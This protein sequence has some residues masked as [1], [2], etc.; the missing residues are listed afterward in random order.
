VDD[1]QE[2]RESDTPGYAD[3]RS[4]VDDVRKRTGKWAIHIKLDIISLGFS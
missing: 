3:H 2:R 1:T 4:A